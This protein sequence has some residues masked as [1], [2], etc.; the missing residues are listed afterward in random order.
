MCGL[1]RSNVASTV[2]EG[3][4]TMGYEETAYWL[5]MAMHRKHPPS[6]ADGVAVP[7]DGAETVAES[8]VAG[9]MMEIAE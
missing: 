4:E 6:D 1:P 7:A 5:G 9:A 8:G 2:T 3:I